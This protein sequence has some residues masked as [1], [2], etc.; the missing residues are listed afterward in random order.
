MFMPLL[1]IDRLHVSVQEKEIL[2][3]LSL[4]I[5]S[6]EIHAIMGPNGSGKS[7]LASTLLAHPKYTVTDGNMT[8]E[9]EDLL[10]LSTDERARK[11]LFLALQYPKE[12]AGVSLR[13]FLLAATEA[14]R[15]ARD[16][17][18]TKLSPVRFAKEI[19]A[20]M[21]S[22]SM[23]PSFVHRSVNQGFSGGEKKKA[24]IL[25]MML[26]KPRLAVL[27]ETDSGLDV[28]ALKIVADGVNRLRSPQFSAIIVTH[29]ARLL[30]YIVPDV[31]HVMIRGKIV[32]SGGA[33]LAYQLEKEGYAKYGVMEHIALDTGDAL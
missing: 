31:V 11:G 1:S 16:A 6:G 4:T 24:E 20:V 7:T 5:N 13:S 3:G 15:Q 10:P 33:D 12:I 32:E 28:D 9:G 2:Q 26:L 18:H 30:E 14:Q 21:Q 17:T 23:D 8:W 27:D 25:Q 29:Y 19:E 22:L